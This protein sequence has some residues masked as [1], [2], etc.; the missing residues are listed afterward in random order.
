VKI[1]LKMDNGYSTYGFADTAVSG[2]PGLTFS[3]PPNE[4]NIYYICVADEL[5]GRLLDTLGNC[6]YNIPATG[7]DMTLNI[8]AG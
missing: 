8:D 4:G 5:A 6:Q 2:T 1:S 3:I 7:E